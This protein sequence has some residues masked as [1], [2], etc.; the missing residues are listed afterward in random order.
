MAPDD[1]N[2]PA[3]SP[4]DEIEADFGIVDGDPPGLLGDSLRDKAALYAL[5]AAN[6]G[7]WGGLVAIRKAYDA[8]WR[9]KEV[10]A[11]VWV[12]IGAGAGAALGLSL[13]ARK[14]RKNRG[15]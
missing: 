3:P 11:R 10:P 1:E 14:R 4:G 8:V 7:A 9:V 12:A 15:D 13:L 6:I 5:G 2:T